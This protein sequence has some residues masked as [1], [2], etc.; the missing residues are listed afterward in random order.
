MDLSFW[1]TQ[2]PLSD[3]GTD[4]K[5]LEAIDALPSDIASLRDI[6]SQFCLHYRAYQ[7]E[8]RE[9]R[10]DEINTRYADV[11]FARIYSRNPSLTAKRS[12]D[13]R[14]VGCC[15]DSALLLVSILRHKGIPARVRVG[16][17]AYFNPGK[18][19]DHTVAEMWD[20]TAERWR[21]VDA[22][23]PVGWKKY[24]NG[25]QVDLLDL[26]PGIDFQNGAE[27]WLTARS[28]EIDPNK[29]IICE[30]N[31]YRGLPYLVG[32]VQVDLAAMNKQ[33]ML[34]WD[35]WGLGL[36]CSPDNIPDEV[37]PV[38][39]EISLALIDKSVEPEKIQEF[40][41]RSNLALTEEILLLDPNLPGMEMKKVNVARA[42][43]R[44]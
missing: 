16:S 38:A 41:K 10:F 1:M 7:S 26:R 4:P 18:M 37:I 25:K 33:E 40:M 13:E 28:G 22:D 12:F 17:A 15:R 20:A 29:Y 23:I 34:P 30:S 24:T 6:A 42:L 2:S 3:P 21:L 43:G 27:A 36:K 39:D 14:T 44:A 11:M 32:N 8:V 35:I 9:E 5:L 19:V 31:S